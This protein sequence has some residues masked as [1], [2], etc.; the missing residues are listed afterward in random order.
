MERNV[1]A[2][3]H[4]PPGSIR[5]D[6]PMAA[7]IDPAP[8]PAELTGPQPV[9]AYIRRALAENRNVQ[10]ARSNVLAMKER[11]PQVTALDDPM[12]Q[13][14]IWPFPS[15][16]PQYSLMGYGPYTM[17][18]SQQ[19]PWFGTLALRGQAAEQDVKIALFELATAQ[20]EAVSE[21]KRSYYELYYNQR[22]EAILQDNRKLAS[23]F[24]EITRARYTTGN[25]SQ[26][27][28]LRAEVTVTELDRELVT[29]AQ[30]V[31]EARAALAQQL[32]VSPEADLRTLPEVT[33][34]T[35]PAEV[36]R[37]YRLAVAARPEL[38]GRLAAVARDERNVELARKNYYP[39]I[40]VGLNYMLMTRENNPSP[41]ADGRDNFDFTVGFNLPV[42]R[43]K[44]DAG[45][46]E[47]QARAV[48]DAKRYDADRDRT[49]REVKELLAQAR[50]RRDIIELFRTSILPKS[51]QALKVATSDYSTGELEFVSLIT[52][53]REVLQVQLQIA[54]MESE[55]GGTLAQLERVVGCQL[56]ENPPRDA[57]PPLSATEQP[58]S[59]PP[60][61][62]TSPFGNGPGRPKPG[63][64]DAERTREA[65]GAA[66]PPQAQPR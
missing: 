44:L 48:A 33:I 50:A 27:D 6:E 62:S 31:A 36:E 14:T 41:L 61:D 8:V 5:T 2:A 34:G 54:R 15:N 19:F 35:V 11:I 38:Q 12:V 26:Q 40:D 49:Y 39:N 47:A 23:D 3:L 21:V 37:L 13:N 59:P 55:L 30:G 64:P 56:N 4:W 58:P 16:G 53:W 9:D 1:H 45:V 63:G 43:G 17:M 32:H 20:L 29:V 22:A 46:R 18:I 52:A 60:A 51:E 28:V 25:T 66:D 10:S 57:P 42:Y 7:A 24:V 65:E